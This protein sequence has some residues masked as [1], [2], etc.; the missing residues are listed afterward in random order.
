MCTIVVG[1]MQSNTLLCR[2]EPVEIN[3]CWIV[4]KHV[5]CV[6]SFAA[7]KAYS[8]VRH[9]CFAMGAKSEK[10]SSKGGRS[11]GASL[12]LTADIVNELK[13]SVDIIGNEDMPDITTITLKSG[14]A[15]VFCLVG[16]K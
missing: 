7:A 2:R 15:T 10:S 14:E 6:Y 5:C 1:R 13:Q 9:V 16:L 11:Q 3:G 8:R 12:M 4:L